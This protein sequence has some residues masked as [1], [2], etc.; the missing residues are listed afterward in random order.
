MVE[1]DYLTSYDISIPQGTDC[2]RVVLSADVQTTAYA[3]CQSFIFNVGQ[4]SGLGVLCY[5]PFKNTHFSQ[6]KYSS[7]LKEHENLKGNI[8]IQIP[9][10]LQYPPPPDSNRPCMLS[11]GGAREPSFSVLQISML[12]NAR[13]GFSPGFFPFKPLRLPAVP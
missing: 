10:I 12:S 9:L 13:G 5:L 8:L 4:V 2:V 7:E 11:G 1:Q 3:Y 6:W